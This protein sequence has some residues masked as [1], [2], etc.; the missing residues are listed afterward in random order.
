MD[1][2]TSDEMGEMDDPLTRVFFYVA[3]DPEDWLPQIYVSFGITEEDMA[4]GV[5]HLP[6]TPSECL[7][8]G[9]SLVQISTTAASLYN[10]LLERT[11]EERKEILLME[12]QLMLS[13]SEFDG[14]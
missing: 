2:P 10:E 1:D 14:S 7:D 11:V 5:V 4:R 3:A 8:V 12:A 13:G 9:A 6:L